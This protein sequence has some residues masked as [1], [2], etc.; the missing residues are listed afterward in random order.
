[1]K[2][3]TSPVPIGGDQRC[4]VVLAD[5]DPLL[6]NL[7]AEVLN[8]ETD[9]QIVACA[10]GG[11]HALEVIE[12]EKPDLLL[13]DL[14]MPDLDGFAVLATLLKWPHRPRVLTLSVQEDDETMIRT[15]RMGA[16]GFVPKRLAVKNLPGAIRKVM[17]GEV[18][19]SRRICGYI[20][21]EFT[22]LAL[23]QRESS[24]PISQLSEREREVLL[25]IAHG[26]T[27]PQIAGELYLSISTVKIH[28]S[29]ILKKLSLPNRTEAAIFAVREGLVGGNGKG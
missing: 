10:L 7:L 29:N 18:W 23:K 8:R 12:R 4:R 9:F 1:M 16:S 3:A 28:V 27:N 21:D 25:R 19:F 13:L 20:F 14:H 17:D 11:R 26:K 5:D 15:A 22:T 24:S 6:Q 2:N